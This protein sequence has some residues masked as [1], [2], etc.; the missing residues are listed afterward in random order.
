[1]STVLISLGLGLIFI[2]TAN[3]VLGRWMDG[4]R[5]ALTVTLLTLLVYVPYAFFAWPG[6][7]VFAIHLA[8][9]LVV[10]LGFGMLLGKQG[11]HRGSAWGPMVIIGFFLLVAA[12][13]T[14][15]LLVSEQGLSTGLARVL[16][17]EPRASVGAMTSGFPGTVAPGMDA[18]RQ[19]YDR[20]IEKLETQ[21]AR[22]WTIRKGWLDT[23]VAGQPARFQVAVD[24][25]QGKP[26]AG[27][28]V[29]GDFLRPSNR[30]H[31]QRFSMHELRKGIYQVELN[32]PDAG[33][34]SLWLRVRVDGE[35][36][37][38]RGTTIVGSR[39]RAGAPLDS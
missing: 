9:Y 8:L 36:H 32:L 31:D 14:I 4:P 25:A 22:G 21:V 29:E 17:P 28:S 12:A 27:A 20:H 7:D 6:G 1:M 16:L 39:E 23:P 33:T 5:A 30:D 11:T 2:V 13:N 19:L 35:Y 3:V 34:W 24:D 15:F 18:R 38:L 26:I 37:E 10:N